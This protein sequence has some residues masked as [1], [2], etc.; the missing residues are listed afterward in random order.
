M[1]KEWETGR[2]EVEGITFKILE[3]GH[4]LVVWWLGLSEFPMQGLRFYPSSEN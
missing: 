2:E 4:P 1:K 3:T